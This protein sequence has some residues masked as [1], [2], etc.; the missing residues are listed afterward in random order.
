M[1]KVLREEKKFILEYLEYC[2]NKS[3][4]SQILPAD[5]HN[6]YR[7]YIVRSLYFDTLWD[8]DFYEKIE[9]IELRKKIR[10]R[11][12]NPKDDFAFLEIKQKQGKYQYKR[13]LKMN[14]VDSLK[15]INGNY[16]V[17]LNYD[18]EF[19]KECYSIMKTEGYFPKTV[20]EYHREAFIAKE[21]SIR[22]TF[23][24]RI[25]AT[26][27][28]F[29]IFDENLP[30]YPVFSRDKVILEV[31]YNGFLLSY[32]KNLMDSC[33]KSELSVSKYCLAR[34][35]SLGYVF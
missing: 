1:R 8:K 27:S 21:N 33:Q 3:I 2:K 12:Y 11:I 24:S 28:N 6:N 35:V 14:K 5:T 25:M 10:L 7:G 19:A 34:Q 4:I 13:S 17:L 29:N 20:V 9:G 23:D 32:I 26:E 15:L 31:K 16:E 18:N 22:L 30:L